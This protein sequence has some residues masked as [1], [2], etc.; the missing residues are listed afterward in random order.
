MFEDLE[1]VPWLEK[2][3]ARLRKARADEMLIAGTDSGDR[4]FTKWILEDACSSPSL[5][6]KSEVCHPNKLQATKDLAISLEVLPTLEKA[7]TGNSPT[8]CG[9]ISAGQHCIGFSTRSAGDGAVI[10]GP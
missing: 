4:R 5:F 1:R 8:P 7:A 10:S 6:S 3:S 2:R 9:K